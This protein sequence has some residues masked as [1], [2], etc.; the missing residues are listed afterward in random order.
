MDI[1]SAKPFVRVFAPAFH[2]FFRR[3]GRDQAIA[4]F[5]DEIIAIDR[6]QRVANFEVVLGLEKLHECSLRFAISQRF[7]NK[8]RLEGKGIQTGVVHARR[9]IQRSGYEVLYLIWLVSVSF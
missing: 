3:P 1:L 2:R 8:D 9:Y 5:A 4:S 7:G 6:S